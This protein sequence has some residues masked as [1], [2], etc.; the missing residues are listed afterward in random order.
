MVKIAAR[1]KAAGPDNSSQAEGKP[2]VVRVSGR[3][4]CK[5]KAIDFYR[6]F[7]MMP[8]GGKDQSS[9]QK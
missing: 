4:T 9:I 6:K 7:S 8:T 1:A 2:W 5:I 3:I